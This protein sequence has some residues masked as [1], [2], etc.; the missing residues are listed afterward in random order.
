MP[1]VFV[2]VSKVFAMMM[3]NLAILVTLQVVWENVRVLKNS[4]ETVSVDGTHL[5][6]TVLC[7]PV[8]EEVWQPYIG[9]MHR[10]L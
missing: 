9:C 4:G 8:A 2:P 6:S 10:Q 5:V 1:S 3:T 7:H